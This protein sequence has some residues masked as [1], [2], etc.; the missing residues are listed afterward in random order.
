MLQR[1]L[2]FNL[3]QH[4][5]GLDSVLSP[6]LDGLRLQ[7][8]LYGHPLEVEYRIGARGHGPQSVLLDSLPLATQPGHN[9]YRAA[10]V[11]LD[12]EPLPE[13]LAAGARHLLIT[14]G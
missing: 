3:Q 10:G 11:W 2:G 14:L 6:A 4:R 7:L 5:F 12:A 1:L 13:R 9:R 8:P